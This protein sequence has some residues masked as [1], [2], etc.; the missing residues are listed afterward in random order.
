MSEIVRTLIASNVLDYISAVTIAEGLPADRMVDTVQMV[1][2]CERESHDC[3]NDEKR[4]T[5]CW[6]KH[7]A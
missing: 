3:D 5:T 6:K 2:A 7:R 4:C 1:N